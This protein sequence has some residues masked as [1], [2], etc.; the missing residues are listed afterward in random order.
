MTVPLVEALDGEDD[1]AGVMEVDR[2]SFATPWT[3][4]MYDAERQN[5]SISFIV[6]LRTPECRVAGY[7]S[8]WLVIDEV[9]INNVAV[10]PE[11]RGRGFGRRLIERAIEDGRRRG[12]IRALLEVRSGNAPARQLYEKLGFA[13]IGVRHAY[14]SEPVDDALVL[15]RRLQNLG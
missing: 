14:Y 10:R 5:S 9:H 11:Y 8:F 15:A 2:S 6:V 1:L 7:C 4:E 13:A 3:R 12:A